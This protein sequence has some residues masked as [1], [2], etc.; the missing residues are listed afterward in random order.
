MGRCSSC[1]GLGLNCVLS[2]CVGVVGG[3]GEVGANRE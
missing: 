2:K 1:A 3:W